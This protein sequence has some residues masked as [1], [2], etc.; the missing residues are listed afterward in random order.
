MSDLQLALLALGALIIIVVVLFN[1]WQERRLRSEASGRFAEPEHDP[2]MENFDNKSNAVAKNEEVPASF[3]APRSELHEPEFTYTEPEITEDSFDTILTKHTNNS[4]QYTESKDNIYYESSELEDEIHPQ[5]ESMEA[6]EPQQEPA[7]T[8]HSASPE[9]V[10][11]P[12]DI[13]QQIDLVAMLYL[14]SPASGMA[15]RELL[16]SMAVD[17]PVYL[18]GL[19]AE[20]TWHLLT[21]EEESAQ[22]SRAVCSLQLADRSGPVTRESLN[23]FQHAVDTIGLKLGAHI[24]WQGGTDPLIYAN[25]LDRFCIEV[26]KMVGFHLIQS[27]GGPFTGTKL[28]GLAEA[29]GLVLREDGA[30]HYESDGGHRLFALTNQDNLPFSAETL[31]ADAF[32]GVNF[33]LDIPRVKNSPEVFNHMV[34]IA[35]QMES[36]LGAALVDDNQRVLSDTMIEKIRQQLKVIHAKMITRGIIPGSNAALR[37]FS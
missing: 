1:W 12:P 15:L 33:Q 2:L 13:H 29:S 28:K 23:R 25:E 30:F 27:S 8:L 35:R 19:G 22:F 21:R 14:P 20:H 36:S 32:R 17:K 24:E 6:F 26:D 31:R 11:L 3:S 4:E 34:L 37:L 5:P 16:L 18:Y 7:T 9:Q 10:T